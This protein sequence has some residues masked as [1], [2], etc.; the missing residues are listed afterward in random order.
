MENCKTDEYLKE[1]KIWKIMIVDDEKDIHKIIR[2]IFDHHLIDENKIE[3]FS[4]YNSFE[5][6]DILKEND[7]I[8]VALVDIVMETED[9]GIDCVK[10]IRDELENIDI[11]LILKTGYRSQIPEDDILKKY[12]ISY[13]RQETD[14]TSQ[15]IHE[16]FC[17]TI[18][19][20]KGRIE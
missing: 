18:K 4:A 7:D 8:A 19:D 14:L 12:D 17:S 16:L 11:R 15:V 20:Y 10:R 9:A 13:F 2:M 1:N 5:A 6:I 3:I